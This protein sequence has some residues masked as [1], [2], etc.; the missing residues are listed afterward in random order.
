VA[1]RD[2]VVVALFGGRFWVNLSPA[3]L[4]V[5]D[6]ASGLLEAFRA[7]ALPLERLG[8]EITES[9]PILDFA[10]ARETLERLHAAGLA[11]A[12]D[13]FGSQNTPLKHLTRLPIAVVKLDRSV[14][15]NIDADHSNR[16]LADAIC[17]ICAAHGMTVLA[18]GVE[19]EREIEALRRIGVS[20]AQGFAISR[21][22]STGDLVEFLSAGAR[23]AAAAR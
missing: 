10:Q 23:R 8:V 20:T 2:P 14:V 16:V 5:A 7:A 18:E 6:A 9:L 13:D 15:S 22:L 21:P 11:I 3:D 12:V 17:A 19:T 1:R 4:A